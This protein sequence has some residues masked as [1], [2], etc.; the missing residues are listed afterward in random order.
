MA[1]NDAPIED[2][3]TPA[4]EEE[5]VDLFVER[6]SSDEN[7]N[8]FIGINGKNYLMPRGKVSRVPKS[9]ALEY[10]R[11]KKAQYKADETA[12]SMKGIKAAE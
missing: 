12:A 5:M 11:S 2:K 4:T 10:E 6:D 7:P 9:V 3:T 1:K 8:C